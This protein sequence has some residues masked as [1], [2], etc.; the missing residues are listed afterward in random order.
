MT[1]PIIVVC[2]VAFTPE[3]FLSLPVNGFS[4]R[5]FKAIADYP[6]FINAFWISIWLGAV[7]SLMALL[8]AVPRRWPSHATGFPVAMLSRHS[9]CRP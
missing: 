4:L 3:G 2:L 1:A 6:E 9:S 5:W 8:F 7:S